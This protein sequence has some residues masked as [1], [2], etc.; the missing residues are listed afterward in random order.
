MTASFSEWNKAANLF[1]K[2]DIVGL[3]DKEHT[4]L[5]KLCKKIGE[6]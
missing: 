3:T 5:K 4:R 6:D 1:S 2:R